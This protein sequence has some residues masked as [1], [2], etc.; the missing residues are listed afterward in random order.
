[1][2]EE[3][4]AGRCLDGA[5]VFAPDVLG[6]ELDVEHGGVDLGMAHEVLEGGQEMPSR[7]MSVPKVCR[8]RWGL[9]SG[10]RVVRR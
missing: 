5:A 7:T 4:K 2:R 3:A 9:A 6:S 1:M 10:I 8:K